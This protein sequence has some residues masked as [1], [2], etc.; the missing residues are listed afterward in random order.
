MKLDCV[1]S[2]FRYYVMASGAWPFYDDLGG[3]GTVL[4]PTSV[5]W[6][7]PYKRHTNDITKVRNRGYIW[8]V[9]AE[10]PRAILGP[11]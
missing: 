7:S 2:T 5:I 10:Y 11:I 8:K 1:V 6:L 4:P 9:R 3:G